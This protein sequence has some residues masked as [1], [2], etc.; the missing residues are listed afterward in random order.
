MQIKK[1][2]TDS[3]KCPM[4]C[5]SNTLHLLKPI[6]LLHDEKVK[7]KSGKKPDSDHAFYRSSSYFIYFRG[8]CNQRGACYGKRIT[9]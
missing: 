2:V 5:C 1:N 7:Q 8:S 9:G 3:Q 4:K 6:K